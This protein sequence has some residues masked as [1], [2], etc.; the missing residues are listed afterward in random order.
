MRW[1]EDVG[2]GERLWVADVLLQ[3][4]HLSLYTRAHLEGFS[5][6][7][8]NSFISFIYCAKMIDHSGIEKTL[9]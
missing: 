5:I 1:G 3:K 7:D 8:F 4:Q 2:V 9:W 6:F